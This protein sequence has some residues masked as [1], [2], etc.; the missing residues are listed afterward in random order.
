MIDTSGLG[1]LPGIGLALAVAVIAIGGLILESWLLTMAVLVFVLG[2]A[3]SIAALVWVL[4][5]D[6]D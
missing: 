3:A 6:E 5:E 4:S 1:L 2:T